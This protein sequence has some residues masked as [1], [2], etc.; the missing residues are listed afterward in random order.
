[1][2]FDPMYF[3]FL[4]P[5]LVLSMWAQWF[6]ANDADA[7]GHLRSRLRIV[8]GDGGRQLLDSERRS[9]RGG[10]APVT[11]FVITVEHTQQRA[12]ERDK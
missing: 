3:V 11:G 7:P 12:R 2:W 10:G 4:L 1:M 8:G 6:L 9:S 5:A